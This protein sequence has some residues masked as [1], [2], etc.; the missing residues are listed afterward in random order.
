MEGREIIEVRAPELVTLFQSSHMINWT[1]G[2]KK[3]IRNIK[4]T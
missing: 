3:I 1:K 4:F 2:N